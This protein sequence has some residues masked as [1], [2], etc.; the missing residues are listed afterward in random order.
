MDSKAKENP[1]RKL[2]YRAH[3][4]GYPQGRFQDKITNQYCDTFGSDYHLSEERKFERHL[5]HPVND[6][7]KDYTMVEFHKHLSDHLNKTWLATR[8]IQY[9]PPPSNF[10]SLSADFRWTAQRACQNGKTAP[11]KDDGGNDK[12]IPGLAIFNTSIIQSHK[13]WHIWRVSDIEEFFLGTTSP[14]DRYLCRWARN[15]EEYVCW[16]L[17]P[18]NALISFTRI[19]DLIQPPDANAAA[20]LTS[21]FVHSEHLWNFKQQQP[22]ENISLEEYTNRAINLVRQLLLRDCA[23]GVDLKEWYIDELTRYLTFNHGLDW[24]YIVSGSYEEVKESSEAMETQ[25]KEELLL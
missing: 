2:L 13:N 25:L 14:I 21:K 9:R 11:E 24:G 7:V 23:D 8:P 17:I 12:Y 15:A 16:G 19:K 6:P 22:K 20:F 4:H 18:Q 1:Y 10:V 3:S 5:D